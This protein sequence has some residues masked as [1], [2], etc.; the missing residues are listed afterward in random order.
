MSTVNPNAILLVKKRRFF[1]KKRSS[2]LNMESKGI[3]NRKADRDGAALIYTSAVISALQDYLLGN[4]MTFLKTSYRSNCHM[5]HVAPRQRTS[6]CKK[7][8]HHQCL[9]GTLPF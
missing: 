6:S 2:L 7:Q 8:K 9:R 4:W 5:T 3:Q 1:A